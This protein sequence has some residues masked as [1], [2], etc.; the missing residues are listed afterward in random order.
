MPSISITILGDPN[1]G[2][3]LGQLFPGAGGLAEGWQPFF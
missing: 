2:A 3:G 1:Q